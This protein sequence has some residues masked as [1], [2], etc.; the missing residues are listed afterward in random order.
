MHTMIKLHYAEVHRPLWVNPVHIVSMDLWDSVTMLRMVDGPGY[1]VKETPDEIMNLVA[2]ASM[3]LRPKPHT[4]PPITN[5]GMADTV[6][7]LREQ[8]RS[9]AA[10]LDDLATTRKF[11]AMCD[12]IRTLRKEINNLGQNTCDLVRMKWRD[13]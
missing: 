2:A 1:K 12:I 13:D 3:G 4:G 5:S 9:I 8:A 10:R 7:E 6:M 11:G